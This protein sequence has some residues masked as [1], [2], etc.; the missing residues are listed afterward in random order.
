M[1][2]DSMVSELK[3]VIKKERE[4]GTLKDADPHTLELWKVSAIDELRCEVT[5]LT[6]PFQPSDSNPITAKPAN[7]LTA[8][9]RSLGDSLSKFANELE[10]MDNLF[11]IFPNQ[12]PSEHIHIIVKA[13]VTGE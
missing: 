7:T 6:S 9:I 10:P 13:P 3:K 5:W 2:C 8:R 4:L 12:P 11:S 1:G